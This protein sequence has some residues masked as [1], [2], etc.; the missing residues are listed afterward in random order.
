MQVKDYFKVMYKHLKELGDQLHTK[1]IIQSAIYLIKN[2]VDIIFLHPHK[3]L[4]RF[5]YLI[6]T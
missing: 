1:P 3:S 5:N 6:I 2:M 4:K